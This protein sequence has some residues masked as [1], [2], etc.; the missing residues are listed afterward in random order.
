MVQS[1]V[2][3]RR[4]KEAMRKDSAVFTSPFALQ[5]AWDG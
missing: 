4:D 5:L 1:E 3:R 2:D